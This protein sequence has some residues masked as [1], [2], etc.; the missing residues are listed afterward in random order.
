MDPE[1]ANPEPS[2]PGRTQSEVLWS[3]WL[4]YNVFASRQDRTSLCASFRLKAPYSTR[5]SIGSRG[6]RGHQRQL[7]APARSS[8]SAPAV[9]EAGHGAWALCSGPLRT[10]KSPRNVKTTR[11]TL[12]R[13]E[14][15][16]EKAECRLVPPSG[17]CALP[18]FPP[19]PLSL[20]D[21]GNAASTD[22]GVPKNLE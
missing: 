20:N 3:L 16:N 8:S 17:E 18:S 6:P 22:L 4:C 11:R 21:L 10:A 15:H 5:L 13:A 19:L 2:L 7:L 1:S 14:S 12:A 9:R